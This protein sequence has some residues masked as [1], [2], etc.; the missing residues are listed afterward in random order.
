MTIRETYQ[1]HMG[2]DLEYVLS[3]NALMNNPGLIDDSSPMSQEAIR[4]F[5]DVVQIES[6]EQFQSFL[7][8]LGE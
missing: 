3:F 8:S 1:M 6:P 2:S 7:D 4:G 5:C